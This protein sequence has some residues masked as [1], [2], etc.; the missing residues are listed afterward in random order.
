M[1]E[2]ERVERMLSESEQKFRSLVETT[3]A[4]IG[5]INLT[6]EFTYVNKALANLGGY[7]VQELVGHPFMEFLHPEDRGA[8]LKVFKRDPSTSEEAPEIRFR[9]K[10]KDGQILTLTSKPTDFEIDGK[11]AGFQAIITDI[12]VRKLAEEALRTSEMKYRVLFENNPHG[13]Y[14]TG[15]DG[16]LL[17]VNAALV[18]LLG[19]DSERE[20]LAADVGRDL[21]ANPEE[22]EKW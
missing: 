6:G 2:R 19:Y 13:I 7:T 10:R 12:T 9:I 3:A 1:T 22:R 17:T 8:V 21:Y 16:R 11:T 15:A 14:Q 5:I 18:R 20:L 4:P